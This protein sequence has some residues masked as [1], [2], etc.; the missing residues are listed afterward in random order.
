MN[1]IYS[2]LSAIS[3]LSN[4]ES[5]SI[6][7]ENFT[8]EK[9]KG[10]MAIH[11][12]GESC[13]RD[14]GQGWKISPS[15]NIK[16]GETFCLADFAGPAMIKHI[17]M[18]CTGG[19]RKLIL[20]IYWDGSDT[21]S[22]ET[23]LNDF[24]ACADFQSF[25]Q[26]TSAAVCLNPG[27][28]FNCYW[29]MPFYKNCRITLENI[30]DNELTVY[31]QIDYIL[32]ELPDN[33][34]YFHAQFRRVN[35]L[36]YKEV[37]TILDHVQ[38]NGQYVGTYLFWQVN[39]NGWWGEGEIKFYLDGDDEFPTSCGTGTEDYFCGAYNFDV[40]GKYTEFCTPY[41]GLPKVIRPDGL[42]SANTKFSVYRWH[43]CDPI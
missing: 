16:A 36:P 33:C 5:R 31:Y 3:R 9:G 21:P 28:A 7:A 41:A 15:V 11:G 37:Y 4:A 27:R 38:G 35:P 24:F 42:Y 25:S 19:N 2:G 8:G 6:S 13:A 12:T 32:T 18:T 39:N 30:D 14:L 1:M 34:A 23:P 22:V 10:G 20:R 43:I 17:W 26:L 40:N 29:E